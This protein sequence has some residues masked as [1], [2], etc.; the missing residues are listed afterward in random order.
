[1][2][3]ILQWRVRDPCNYKTDHQDEVPGLLAGVEQYLFLF[4]RDSL[5]LLSD[6][7]ITADCNMLEEANCEERY[8]LATQKAD[9]LSVFLR[10]SQCSL[11]WGEFDSVSQEERDFPLAFTIQTYT[12]A[13]N[14]ELQLKT[15][16]RPHN[17]YC[18]HVDLKGA[19]LFL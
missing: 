11:D 12:D 19:T 2:Q 15:I 4:L 7:N 17:S 5:E 3:W 16:F 8:S 1:M 18:I 6:M 13:R 14:L 9:P 10:G